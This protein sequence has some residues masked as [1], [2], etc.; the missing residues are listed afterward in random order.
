VKL[1][2]DVLFLGWNTCA[3]LVAEKLFDQGLVGDEEKLIVAS[4]SDPK[5]GERCKWIAGDPS[6]I[7]DEIR[8]DAIELVLAFF[9]MHDDEPTSAADTRSIIAAFGA[10]DRLKRKDA[11]IVVEIY[12]EDRLPL[13]HLHLGERVEVVFKEKMDANLI[14]NT[15]VN[16]GKTSEL[17]GEMASFERNRIQTFRLPELLGKDEGRVGDVRLELCERHEPIILLGMLEPEQTEPIV[18]PPADQPLGPG[19]VL[20]C[21]CSEEHPAG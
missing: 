12:D 10:A 7:L 13:L 11:R 17:I 14:A 21:L 4:C 16:P 2:G 1:P 9:E 8:W 3:Q 18:N 19:H 15:I 20:Y 6:D 5:L